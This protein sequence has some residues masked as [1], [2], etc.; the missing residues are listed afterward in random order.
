MKFEIKKEV[1]VTSMNKVV[2]VASLSKF[3]PILNGIYISVADDGI[4]LIGSNGDISIKTLI[5]KV[6]NDETII[7]D[8]E[9]GSIVVQ[10]KIFNDII[11]KLPSKSVSI[12]VDAE[13]HIFVKS[14]KSKF[15][16]NGLDSTEYPK[17]PNVSDETSFDIP[18]N[19]LKD[20][21]KETVISVANTET[22]PILNGVN[23]QSANNSLKFIATDSH[24]L[25]QRII[26]V[27]EV[28]ELE[29]ITVPGRSLLELNK[30]LDGTNTPVK[31][32]FGNN[33]VLF[34]ANETYLYSRILEGNF[35]DVSRLIPDSSTT[36][37]R[38]SKKEI[39]DT[40]ERASLL[41]KEKG[42]IK[43]SVNGGLMAEISSNTAEIGNLKE[44][45]VMLDFEGDDIILSFSAAYAMDGLKAISQDE[46]LL[47]FNGNSRPFV[48]TPT[49]D[50]SN[51]QLILPIRTI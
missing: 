1:L 29:S 45:L 22:R 35:P 3:I 38:A 20:V 49:E 9:V 30:I 33:Q 23:I 24:R 7:N 13:N 21:I 10:A 39:L 44:E 17:L 2:G 50:E 41:S 25:S 8:I 15:N 16:L 51:L 5:P 43:F 37:I 27:S 42:V 48:I 32:C 28:S 36:K 31:V 18:S 14:G 34:I 40:I 47:N 6:L 46:V 12:S 19:E 11:K 4:T 26:Q